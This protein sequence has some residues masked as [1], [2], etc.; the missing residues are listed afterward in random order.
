MK[1]KSRNDGIIEVYDGPFG[2]SIAGI[3]MFFM[4]VYIDKLKLDILLL[5]YIAVIFYVYVPT[6][7]KYWF[8]EEDDDETV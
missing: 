5:C 7:L 1:E 4:L 2:K 6:A 8:I 3:I